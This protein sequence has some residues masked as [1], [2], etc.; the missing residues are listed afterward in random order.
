MEEHSGGA[1]ARLGTLLIYG[2]KEN[3][4]RFSLLKHTAIIVEAEKGSQI[5][6]QAKGQ[7]KSDVH[8][9][10]RHT[11]IRRVVRSS[12]HSTEIKIG[13]PVSTSI[14]RLPG[15]FVAM[16]LRHVES[17]RGRGFPALPADKPQPKV[18]CLDMPTQRLIVL[19][20]LL[21]PYGQLAPIPEAPALWFQVVAPSQIRI[22]LVR[23]QIV[24]D[25][26]TA[27][28]PRLLL[29]PDPLVL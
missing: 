2:Y 9:N 23:R 17:V 5:G 21:P 20:F 25:G 14:S 10:A 11:V 3:L 13:C 12:A 18:H 26:V 29:F 6:T 7:F 1:T 4:L 16:A 8:S 15:T 27:P 19:D 22:D 28:F 24:R